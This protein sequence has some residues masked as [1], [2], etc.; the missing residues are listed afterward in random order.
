MRKKQEKQE[1]QCSK[2]VKRIFASAG[3]HRGYEYEDGHPITLH[4]LLLH[5]LYFLCTPP[6]TGLLCIIFHRL[7][8]IRRYGMSCSLVVV[9][10]LNVK[11]LASALWHHS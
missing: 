2:R 11:S 5:F 9:T 1:K 3:C 8:R 7:A 4:F 6:L 10:Q